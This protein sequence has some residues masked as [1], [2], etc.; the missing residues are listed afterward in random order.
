[1][2]VSVVNK[3]EVTEFINEINSFIDKL[4]LS[5]I[6]L[7][8]EAT[9]TIKLIANLS[10]YDG[11]IVA[12][13]EKYWAD[14]G[15]TYQ[16]HHLYSQFKITGATSL[17]N[18]LVLLQKESDYLE[19]VIE[20]FK[21][22]LLNMDD[23]LNV[24]AIYMKIVENIFRQSTVSFTN[25]LNMVGVLMRQDA[26]YRCYQNLYSTPI[27]EN[28][29]FDG[30]VGE[31][32]KYKGKYLKYYN[33]DGVSV[34]A[35]LAKIQLNE[36]G[37]LVITDFQNEEEQQNFINLTSRYYTDIMQGS[38]RYTDTFRQMTSDNLESITLA[39]IDYDKDWAANTVSYLNNDKKNKIC[40]DMNDANKN[41]YYQ[42]D[43]YTHELGHVF[44]NAISKKNGTSNE[45]M[46]Y[47]LGNDFY[48]I[49][50]QVDQN[51]IGST[52]ENVISIT[53]LRDYARQ[54]DKNGRI[55]EVPETFAELC[56]EYYGSCYPSVN[57][58]GYSPDDLADINI[59]LDG[60]SYTNLYEIMDDIMKNGTGLIK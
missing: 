18:K 32:I 55:I 20:K 9:A 8:D 26:E 56:A 2:N 60:Y 10:Q 34:Y 57:P 51:D 27:L 38:E 19:N 49:R 48:S 11:K 40:I 39:Y 6:N 42:L 21:D 50:E 54:T 16:N 29:E 30:Y 35:P 43:A 24:I 14:E 1:M 59:H 36:D 5:L 25:K 33:K 12:G 22:K 44:D 46:W 3:D 53:Y 7:G 31:Q 58:C 41:Y 47:S 15:F 23:S 4:K 13:T 28:G 17:E 52:S 45:M 37:G